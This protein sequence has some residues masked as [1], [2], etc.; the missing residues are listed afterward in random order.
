MILNN[1]NKIIYKTVLFFQ[2]PT[3]LTHTGQ[4]IL[5]QYIDNKRIIA[6]FDLSVSIYYAEFKRH[7][8]NIFVLNQIIH[9]TIAMDFS[10]SAYNLEFFNFTPEQIAAE[11]KWSLTPWTSF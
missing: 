2:N 7:F 11:S 9:K 4:T 8:V 1:T 10:Q 5:K 3:T 6:L